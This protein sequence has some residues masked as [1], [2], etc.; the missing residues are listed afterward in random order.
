MDLETSG[1]D[2]A[3]SNMLYMLVTFDVS[4]EEFFTLKDV[5]L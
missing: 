1:R 3:L 5:A 2:S 4:K